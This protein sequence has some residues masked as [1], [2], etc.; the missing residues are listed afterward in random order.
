MVDP[1]YRRRCSCYGFLFIGLAGTRVNRGGQD[2]L[3]R[4]LCSHRNLLFS[5]RMYLPFRL[6]RYR[7]GWRKN[8][9]LGTTVRNR[10]DFIHKYRGVLRDG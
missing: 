9:T 8:I 1:I 6:H 2:R 4:S 10:R 5:H 3:D 7:S